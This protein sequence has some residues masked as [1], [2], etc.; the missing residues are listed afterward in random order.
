MIEAVGDVD[1]GVGD[2][3]GGGGGRGDSDGE[4]VAVVM[5][6]L[7]RFDQRGLL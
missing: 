2:G 6:S 5:K 1:I 7:Q 3:V 4:D